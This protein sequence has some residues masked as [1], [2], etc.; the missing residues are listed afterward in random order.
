MISISD[1]RVSIVELLANASP[2]ADL[3]AQVVLSR[4]LNKPRSWLAAHPETLLSPAQREAVMRT[5]SRLQ[6]GEPLPYIL[7]KWEFFGLELDVTPDVLIPRPE[8]E[9]LVERAIKWLQ[10]SPE[11]RTMADVGTG[12]GCIAISLALRMPDAKLM[13]T[14]ISL[15]AL[16]IARKNAH[17]YRVSTQIGF[18]QCDLLPPHP[19]HLS[20][21]LHFDLICAN[22]PYIPTETLR[23]LPIFGREPAQALDGGPDGLDIVRRLLDIAPE[24]LAPR[25]MLLLEIEASQGLAALS[26][27]YDR[28]NDAMISLHKDLAGRDRLLQIEL[29]RR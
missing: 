21:D 7:G 16:K 3:D 9:L 14:D 2:T 23:N 15:P 24:W 26:L 22:L 6:A 4:V 29:L 25:G 1:L 17:K 27:A 11:R 10:A 12:S 5:V 18:I 13:A 28:F 20:T 19:E 8:T